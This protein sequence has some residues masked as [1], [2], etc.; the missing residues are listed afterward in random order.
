MTKERGESNIWEA[1][2]LAE[3]NVLNLKRDFDYTIEG[4][5]E[6]KH[7]RMTGRKIIFNNRDTL[8]VLFE[9]I[10]PLVEKSKAD[11]KCKEMQMVTVTHELRTP[12]SGILSLLELLQF[13]TNPKG[14]Q[15]V[16][17]IINIAH[18]LL[19]LINDIMVFH[20]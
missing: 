10:S 19:N 5:S 16:Q 3:K 15:Y 8:L 6:M 2:V 1:I 4:G 17:I 9:D 20:I 11:L 7:T 13:E 18:F 14:K 12:V